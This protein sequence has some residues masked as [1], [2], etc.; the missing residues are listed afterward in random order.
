MSFLN[1][2]F[3]LGALAAAVPVLLHLIRQ[4]DAKRIDFPSL[5][6]LRRISRR[7]IRFQKLRHLLLLLMRILV[8][9]LIAL[10]FTRPYRESANPG[11]GSGRVETAYIILLDNSMS[12]AYRDRMPR[13]K[14]EAAAIASRAR[15]GDQVAL[16]EFSDQTLVRV[17]LTADAAAVLGQINAVAVTDH[18]TRYG[19]ALK[20]AEKVALEAAA[21]RRT[22]YLVTDFQKSG[23]SADEQDFRLAGGI[24]LRGVNAGEAEFSNLYLADGRVTG[25]EGG[26][27]G[28][29]KVFASIVNSGGRDRNSS[30]VKATLDGH[31]FAEKTVDLAQGAVEKVEFTTP[32]LA[33]GPHTAVL[34]VEDPALTQD[35]RFSMKFVVRGRRPVISVEE[36]GRGGR[37][38]GVYLNAALNVSSVSP[39]SLSRVSPRTFE[40]APTAPGALLIWNDVSASTG[41][42][43]KR[44]EEFVKGGGGLVIVAADSSS[45]AAFN[46]LFG[47][48]LPAR[49]EIGADG[50]ASRLR[51]VDDY[52]LL[53][54]LRMDHPIFRPFREPHSG[55]FSSVRFFRHARLSTGEGADVLARFDNGDPALVSMEIGA[56][57][58]LIFAS[59]ADDSGNDMP[60]KAIYAPLWQQLLRFVEKFRED[61]LWYQVGDSIEPKSLLAEAAVAAGRADFDASGS[62]VVV[63]PAGHRVPPGDGTGAVTLDQSGFYDIRSSGLAAGIAVNTRPG[64]SDLTHEDADQL[65]AGWVSLQ[66]GPAPVDT[67]TEPLAPEEKDQQQRLWRFLLLAALALFVGEGLLSNRLVLRQ[68]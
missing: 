25:I 6:F 17:P 33:A 37:S 3:L 23:L 26:R 40:S 64:E 65:I 51:P 36:P 4:A 28:L 30:R 47:G 43:R 63:D 11:A 24:D 16:L 10:A 45:A 66:P 54:D 20:A 9:V 13:A 61:R 52:R 48:W 67:D 58:V 39:F 21:A 62:V 8:L 34:E 56:G 5:M 42:S 19:Q 22:I 15:P 7:Y 27:E 1:P 31:I 49:V 14:A 46:H 32:A 44:L 41:S 50:G 2:L 53:M 57:R 60:L 55:N 18:A 35:N 59:S 38:P 68:E 29:M 12:M